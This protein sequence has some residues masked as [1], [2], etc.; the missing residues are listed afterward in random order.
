IRPAEYA[1]DCSDCPRP[2]RWHGCRESSWRQGPAARA[3]ER[4]TGRPGKL[5]SPVNDIAVRR[6]IVGHQTG[7]SLRQPQKVAP[8][9]RRLS[10]GHIA[11]RSE[12]GDA[13]ATAAGTAALLK[14]LQK[15][16]RPRL[17]ESW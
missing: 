16:K 8:P 6:S 11:L 9:S 3:R 2:G 5:L 7:P 14:S 1:G 17:I 10:G 15:R 12:G 13:L 4:E